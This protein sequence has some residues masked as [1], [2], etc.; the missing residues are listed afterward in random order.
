MIDEYPILAALA[1]SAE[2]ATVMRGIG[3]LRVKESDRIAVMA[4]GLAACGVGV[5]EEPRRPDRPRRGPGGVAGGATVRPGDHRIAMSVP[6]SS[7]SPR[8]RRSPSTTRHDRHQLP[9]LRAADARARRA[10]ARRHDLHRRRRRAGRLGQGHDRPRGGGALRP[11]HLD[12]G[13]LY[14]AVGVQALEDGHGVLDP[15]GRPSSPGGWRRTRWRATT[16]GPARAG[17]AA[18]GRGP[19]RGARGAARLPAALRP[20]RGRRGARRARHRHGD[21]PEAPAKLFVTASARRARR[22]GRRSSARES[23]ADGARRH[24]HPRRARRRPRRRADGGGG[25]RGLARHHRN[26]Y[27]RGRRSGRRLRATVDFA[28]EGLEPGCPGS[29]ISRRSHRHSERP[30]EPTA[31]PATHELENCMPSAPTRDDFA[32]LLDESFE[33][34]TPEEGTVVKGIVVAIEKDRPSSTSA[35]RPK[36]ASP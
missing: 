25:R 32:A 13:L 16:C 12:T 33:L 9:R 8:R 4:A 10:G 24:P 3:E 7:A 15:H 20:A 21:R 26:D 31:W 11:A 17:Q 28:R 29:A 6:L 19:A 36:A 23:V 2:G 27:R 34:E 35:T 30:A 5:E 18:S 1:A 14:R 22:G